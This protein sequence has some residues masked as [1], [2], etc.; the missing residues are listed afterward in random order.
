MQRSILVPNSCQ[1][2]KTIKSTVASR[3][4]Q[5]LAP[6]SGS[7]AHVTGASMQSTQQWL[8][9]DASGRHQY[10]DEEW[11]LWRLEQSA[12]HVIE[13]AQQRAV[14]DVPT[15][16]QAAPPVAAQVTFDPWAVTNADIEIRRQQDQ[17]LTE[18]CTSIVS[19]LDS[20]QSVDASTQAQAAAM[21][22]LTRLQTWCPVHERSALQQNRMRMHC[23][24]GFL[25][26]VPHG[27]PCDTSAV[28]E[29]VLDDMK[30]KKS[31]GMGKRKYIDDS[32]L[33]IYW[34]GSG[35]GCNAFTV[36]R[37]VPECLTR[38]GW[39][40]YEGKWI[41]NNCAARLAPPQ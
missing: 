22:L 3:T 8:D 2:A 21:N 14:L 12:Q 26:S 17:R 35:T 7:M 6:P 5:T 15:V 27:M 23:A 40:Q 19:L 34:C 33:S 30:P 39:C 25:R 10:T 4:V 31:A 11:R 28:A 32:D 18:F 24:C 9:H 38:I 37:H 13:P 16:P 1:P 20:L 36:V 29:F 41:C